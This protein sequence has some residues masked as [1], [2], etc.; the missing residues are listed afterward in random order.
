[1]VDPEWHKMSARYAAQ[2]AQTEVDPERL[3]KTLPSSSVDLHRPPED[4]GDQLPEDFEPMPPEDE[5]EQPV[6]G[7]GPADG[8]CGDEG[9][10]Y[11]G[12]DDL[13]AHRTSR[14]FE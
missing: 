8:D 1:V 6:R 14:P 9:G 2:A 11:E 13:A 3:H 12:E 7:E 5:Y 10:E 4:T